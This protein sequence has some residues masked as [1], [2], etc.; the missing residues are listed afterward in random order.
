MYHHGENEQIIVF[1]SKKKAAFESF[2]EL[3]LKAHRLEILFEDSFEKFQ[4]DWHT[5][6][7]KKGFES[8]RKSLFIDETV[9]PSLLDWMSKERLAFDELLIFNPLAL[10][11]SQSI[12]KQDDLRV[13]L[14]SQ[15]RALDDEIVESYEKLFCQ[16]ALSIT[17]C[18]QEDKKTCFDRLA[19]FF[20]RYESFSYNEI[21][22]SLKEKITKS[23]VSPRPIAWVL[24]EHDS[25]L[26]LA[27]FSFFNA[28]SPDILSLSVL[29]KPNGEMK[30][31]ARNLLANKE[32]VIHVPQ[33]KDYDKVDASG[34][35]MPYDE[36]EV[37]KL[38]LELMASE[39]VEVPSLKNSIIAFEVKLLNHQ[40]LENKEG[41]K[42]VTD[43][44][45]LRIEHVRL[46]SDYFEDGYAELCDLDLLSRLGGPYYGQTVLDEQSKL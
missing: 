30:D 1:L 18:S 2:Y 6:L 37:E 19:H 3:D 8:Y 32:A 33:V 34:I 22:A 39:S 4:D 5:F 16:K 45:L 23:F 13:F 38:G 29:R 31:T 46:L 42:I 44:F 28:A 24:T 36:S 14:G 20:K 15:E 9:L 7:E 41:S 17:A 25:I 10:D 12:V 26:N 43:F 21:E 35:A 27:P 40:E 11:Q